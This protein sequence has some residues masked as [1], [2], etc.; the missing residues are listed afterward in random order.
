MLVSLGI[1]IFM[2]I[3]YGYYPSARIVFL[4]IF[5]FIAGL[6]AFALGLWFSALNVRIRDIGFGIGFLVRIW[7]YLTPVAYSSHALPAPYT[8]LYILNPMAS[9]VEG[10]R[11]ALF[12]TGEFPVGG[13]M[14]S[15]S[16][17]SLILVSGLYYF[18]RVETTFAD[19]V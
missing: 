17:T 10:F 6:I 18:K 15:L 8:D 2:M 4:P 13:L 14:L 1:L 16:I 5:L 11:W 19:V 12:S 7:L 9:V 3:L